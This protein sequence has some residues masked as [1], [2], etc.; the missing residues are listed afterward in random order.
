[1]RIFSGR[2]MTALTSSSSASTLLGAQSSRSNRDLSA[3][4]EKAACYKMCAGGKIKKH[5][6]IWCAG[7]PPH[8]GA[9]PFFCWSQS[10]DPRCGGS[11]SSNL[12]DVNFGKMLF[13][14]KSQN[15]L[16]GNTVSYVSTSTHSH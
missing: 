5:S 15:L 16:R 12:D 11:G 7:G 2:V 8:K 3:H 4:K 14:K 13:K 9:A 6:T 1:M 10:F